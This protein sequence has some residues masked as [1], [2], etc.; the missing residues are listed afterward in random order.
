M[1]A[2]ELSEYDLIHQPWIPCRERDGTVTE[3]GILLTLG[4]AHE[5][6]GLSG[7]VPTQTFALT[8][9][10]L[11]VLH[12]AL[13][14]PRDLD[15]WEELWKQEKLPVA[16]IASY[17]AQH[18]ERF[19][20]FH[21]ETPFLQVADLHTAKGETSEL[22]KLVADVPNG[23]PFF[24][25][26]QG[27]EFD[28][29]YAEAARWLLHC[30]AFDPSG[31]RSGVVGDK[32][33]KNGKSYPIG[34]AWSGLLGG[35]LLE[36]ATLRETLLL[37]LVAAEF[38]GWS[39]DVEEDLPVW[40]RP[41]VS[42]AEEIEGGCPPTGPVDLYT[43]QSRRIRLF[44]EDGRVTRVLIS[45]GEKLTPQNK[46]R[47]ELHTAWRRSEAQ[48]KKPGVT[49]IVY[50]PREHNPDR[51]IWRG[52]E[53]LLPGVSSRQKG[54]GGPHL[55]PGVVDWLSYLT[56]EKV[57]PHDHQLRL[58]AIGMI[59]GSNSSVTDD[60]VHDTL[61]LR[62]ML[63]RHDAVGLAEA[64]KSC[65]RAAESAVKA[66][67]GLAGDLAVAAGGDGAGPRSRTMEGAYAQLDGPFRSWL[68]TIRP[69]DDGA[70]PDIDE[71]RTAWHCTA[72]TVVVEAA[73][74]LLAN[75]PPACWEGR[76]VRGH[77]LTAAHAEA[78]FWKSLREA[79][80]G[81]FH[82]PETNEDEAA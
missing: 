16:R 78:K 60:I 44:A 34:A 74:E 76:Q 35:V 23:V 19:D 79:V 41:P 4:R 72:S 46:Y 13:R 70:D 80:P 14:G 20:L 15:E 32:R 71:L 81:A 30:Q 61:A 45:N 5:L 50:M 53:S 3:Q 66:V 67:G 52:L 21:P 9:L 36:G 6:A 31:I 82:D 64:V 2:G 77:L 39:R 48:E 47:H 54:E 33:A 12:G 49:G 42:A 27:G 18:R 26:R 57:I 55:S 38:D 11:A 69:T 28:L 73:R 58:R 62:A 24:S 59:Y 63:A 8:R 56:V 25:V 43:W 51:A 1:P 68:L 40:E 29:S 22:S 17:L 65:V 10:L 7:D 75:V 37:N